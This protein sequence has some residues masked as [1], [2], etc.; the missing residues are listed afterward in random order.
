MTITFNGGVSQ[1]LERI[2]GDLRNDPSKYYNFIKVT[3]SLDEGA[4]HKLQ[5]TKEV[6]G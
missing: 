6:G 5:N 4:V 1:S 2:E 3:G